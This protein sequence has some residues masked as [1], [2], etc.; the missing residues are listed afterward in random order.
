M[1]PQPGMPGP[2]L[3]APATGMWPPMPTVVTEVDGAM[4]FNQHKASVPLM[5]NS[6][7]NQLSNG[8]QRPLNL[9][10]QQEAETDAKVLSSPNGSLYKS[11]NYKIIFLDFFSVEVVTF[12]NGVVVWFPQIEE[13]TM[14]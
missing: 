12:L 10:P 1:R 11:L 6:H 14:N 4:Q 3:M 5:E 2:Q 8:D 9:V 7:M 13:G